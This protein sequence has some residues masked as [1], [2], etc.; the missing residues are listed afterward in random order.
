MSWDEEAAEKAVHW[1]WTSAKHG[2]DAPA[3]VFEVL[4]R[5][6]GTFFIALPYAG[7]PPAGTR[8]QIVGRSAEEAVAR[9]LR[10]IECR[11]SGEFFR[12]F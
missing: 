10:E 11:G 12:G 3:Q 9:A 1:E 7:T 4:Q 6:D 8:L 5:S 2:A